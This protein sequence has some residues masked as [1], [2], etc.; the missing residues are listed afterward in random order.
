VADPDGSNVKPLTFTMAGP[1]KGINIIDM[2]PAPTRGDPSAVFFLRSLDQGMSMFAARAELATGKVDVFLALP[3][4]AMSSGCPNFL[5]T[6][7]GVTV[8]YMACDSSLANCSFSARAALAPVRA[9]RRDARAA[10]GSAN[11]MPV[12]AAGGAAVASRD[13]N[14]FNYGVVE[15]AK[16]AAPEKLVFTPAFNVPLTDTPDTRGSYSIT[17]C[18]QIH[19]S[20]S[21]KLITCQG[22]DPK[23][24]FDQIVLLDFASGANASAISYVSTLLT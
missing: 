10:W 19:G 5:E 8:L 9:S 21:S 16:G 12:P 13:V 2:C 18:D 6:P 4:Y 3:E 14:W 23:H 1:Y 17:Q 7:S 15:M 11:L 22:A 24:S 20:P